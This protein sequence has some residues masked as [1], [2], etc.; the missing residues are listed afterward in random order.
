VAGGGRALE[1]LKNLLLL[2]LRNF[3]AVVSYCQQD[4]SSPYSKKGIVAFSFIAA[5]TVCARISLKRLSSIRD[6]NELLKGT[7]AIS[8]S[9]NPASKTSIVPQRELSW[10]RR[11]QRRRRLDPTSAAP[12]TVSPQMAAKFE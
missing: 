1:R 10:S 8:R 9:L 4:A 12:G 6:L 5:I 7:A 11:F 2:V 3:D